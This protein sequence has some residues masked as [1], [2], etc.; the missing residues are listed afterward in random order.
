MDIDRFTAEELAR[1]A[2]GLRRLA[3]RLVTDPATADDLVQQTMV[4]GLERAPTESDALGPWLS[5]ILRNLALRRWRSR[6]NQSARERA[7][8]RPEA[9]PST[10]ELIERVE[11]HRVVAD[12]VRALP[13][14]ARCRQTA[15]DLT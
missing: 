13:D 6:E 5:R 14:P 12:E 4:A 10:A 3:G 8:A 7:S 1:H 9:L 11:L 15:S 2:A